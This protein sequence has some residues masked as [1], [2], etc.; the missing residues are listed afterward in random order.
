MPQVLLILPGDDGEMGSK[1]DEVAYESPS[2]TAARLNTEL[3]GMAEKPAK[4][5]KSAGNSRPPKPAPRPKYQQSVSE[6]S[7]PSDMSDGSFVPSSSSPSQ[8]PHSVGYDDY[9]PSSSQPFEEEAFSTR[10]V[11]D[12]QNREQL[13]AQV[14]EHVDQHGASLLAEPLLAAVGGDGVAPGYMSPVAGAPP[15]SAAPI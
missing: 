14:A 12:L 11:A 6:S 8:S 1:P 15:L 9:I 3:S 7:S 13:E 10:H 5:A 2:L 4:K